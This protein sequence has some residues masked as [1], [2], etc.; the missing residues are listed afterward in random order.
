MVYKV[1]FCDVTLPEP[2]KE[3]IGSPGNAYIPAG[4]HPGSFVASPFRER[5][6]RREIVSG[7]W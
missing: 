7:A 2:L 6:G 3:S 4:L 1:H 5:S